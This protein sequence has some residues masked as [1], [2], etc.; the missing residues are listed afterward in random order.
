MSRLA[1]TAGD[2]RGFTRMLQP[3]WTISAC[4]LAPAYHRCALANS[5]RTTPLSYHTLLAFLIENSRGSG[6]SAEAPD[7][8]HLLLAVLIA[9]MAAI[10]ADSKCALCRV[11]CVAV[12]R[13]ND[14]TQLKMVIVIVL[15]GKLS[16][17]TC[18]SL[19][20]G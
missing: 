17:K 9:A 8:L 12:P 7:G 20:V 15:P 13:N 3:V 6:H 11:W 2:S 5:T 18:V 14:K 19:G 1:R 16:C 10:A 4:S